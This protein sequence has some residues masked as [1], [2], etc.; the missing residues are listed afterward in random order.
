LRAFLE[1]FVISFVILFL[2]LACIRWFASTVVFL[3]FFTSIVLLACVLGMSAGCLAAS[4]RFDCL[5]TM[6]PLTLLAVILAQVTLWGYRHHRVAIGV[7]NNQASPQQVYFGTE[8]PQLGSSPSTVPIE[9]IAGVFYALIALMFVGPGQMLGRTLRIIPDRLSAYA[10]NLAGSLAGIVAFSL[11]SY[12]RAPPAVWFAVALVPVLAFL[13]RLVWLQAVGLGAVLLLA[14]YEPTPDFEDDEQVSW[15]PYYKVVYQPE[16][17]R[18]ATNNIGHQQMLALD[19]AGAGYRLPYL[20]NRDSGGPPRADVLIIGAGSGNDVQAALAQGATNVDAV[21]IDPRLYEIGRD[22]HPGHP[23]QDPRAAIHL[24]DGR[25]FLRTTR[26]T[27]DQITYALVDSLVLHSG[28][29][30]L[31]LESFLFTEQ[32]FRA[33]RRRLKPEGVFVMCNYYRQ[34]FVVGRLVAMAERVF[35]TRPI[36]LSLPYQAQITADQ[37]QQGAYTLVIVGRSDGAVAA[38]RNRFE[39]GEWF[40]MQPALRKHEGR[41]SFSREPPGPL[42]PEETGWL[43]IGPAAVDT[44]AIG[45]L[46]TDDWPFLYLRSAT[47]PA[48][49]LRGIAIMLT[50]SLVILGLAAP[51]ATVRPN[52]PMFFLGAGFML[53]ENRGVVHLALL[54][55]ST[56]IVSAIVFSAIL[57]MV[58]LSNLYVIAV[59]PRRTYPVYAMLLASLVLNILLPADVFLALPQAARVLGACTVTFLPIFFAGVIFATAFRCSPRPDVD[60]GS[61]I[62]GVVFGGL[63]EYLSLVFGFNGLLVIACLFY[64]LA[65]L[66]G[67][68]SRMP[69][70]S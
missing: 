28:Y 27:Y 26:K 29:S 14:G 8:S 42:G 45:R 56:W 48:F 65:A 67:A 52:G 44:S 35:G 50:V 68:R 33:V 5:A 41:N 31:R 61:N 69:D 3:T 17:G 7:G 57:V 23:Y 36:V 1:L 15:S 25:S 30:S 4:R 2:E 54:F 22:A 37:R 32:A 10:T 62:G 13:N 18:I 40:W 6:I 66:L 12:A 49:N 11:V 20:L 34:G 47:I 60:M 9:I 24:G 19:R 59:P 46:P 39:R 58:L 43:K 21:E 64:L 55:G 38:I 51:L 53:L 16:T 70:S 63:S